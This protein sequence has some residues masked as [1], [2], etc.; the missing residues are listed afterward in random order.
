MRSSDVISVQFLMK[1]KKLFWASDGSFSFGNLCFGSKAGVVWSSLKLLS[2]A[3]RDQGTPTPTWLVEGLG[4]I[5]VR[6]SD[7]V[8]FR[9]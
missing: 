7:Q 8:T 2:F 9:T 5:E 4:S 6:W 3:S 1:K